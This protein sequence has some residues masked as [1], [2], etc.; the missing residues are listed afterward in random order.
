MLPLNYCLRSGCTIFIT[1]NKWNSFVFEWLR[2]RTTF[3]EV[4]KVTTLITHEPHKMEIYCRHSYCKGDQYGMWMAK[5]HHVFQT[6]TLDQ[7]LLLAHFIE[8]DFIASIKKL[9]LIDWKNNNNFDWSSSYL[10]TYWRRVSGTSLPII[11]SC[12]IMKQFLY[13]SFTNLLLNVDND[14]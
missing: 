11:K 2:H 10:K 6:L 5:C 14:V 9:V 12:L 3:L 1:K 4:W 8:K 7:K 13:Y